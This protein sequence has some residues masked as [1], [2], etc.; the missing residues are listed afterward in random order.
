MDDWMY[1]EAAVVEKNERA[2]QA[3]DMK[4]IRAQ[5]EEN[6]QTRAYVREMAWHAV[7]YVWLADRVSSGKAKLRTDFF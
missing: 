3:R 1:T 7:F 6:V 5:V 2:K 4:P